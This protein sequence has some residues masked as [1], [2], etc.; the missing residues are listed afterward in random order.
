MLTSCSLVCLLWLE[1]VQD[2]LSS[3]RSSQSRKAQQNRSLSDF[4]DG[5]WL[6]VVDSF[7]RHVSIDVP[8]VFDRFNS[9]SLGY[10]ININKYTYQYRRIST[11]QITC[12]GNG[13][14]Q[15]SQGD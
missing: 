9:G 14:P 4:V 12:L 6:Q 15:V 5:R 7:E 2:P 8:K 13:T 1:H 11:C 3:C 10:V